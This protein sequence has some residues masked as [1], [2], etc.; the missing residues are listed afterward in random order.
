MNGFELLRLTNEPGPIA[1]AQA[2]D[3]IA[4][5]SNPL[6]DIYQLKRVNFVMKD[7]KVIR[8]P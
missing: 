6:D 4:P 2:A 3:M 8:K 5:P 1:V 7:G